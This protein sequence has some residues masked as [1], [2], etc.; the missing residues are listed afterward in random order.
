MIVPN[1]SGARLAD[2]DRKFLILA[3][4]SLMAQPDR[5]T[6]LPENNVP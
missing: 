1:L 6:G 3:E 5:Q 4:G 2:G